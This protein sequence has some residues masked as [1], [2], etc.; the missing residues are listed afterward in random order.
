MGG[1]ARLDEREAAGEGRRGKKGRERGELITNCGS[2][3][4]SPSFVAK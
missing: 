2:I 4:F 1:G 3:G